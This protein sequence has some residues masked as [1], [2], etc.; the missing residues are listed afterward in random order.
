MCERWRELPSGIDCIDLEARYIWQSSLDSSQLSYLAIEV[1]GKPDPKL[2]GAGYQRGG[3]PVYESVS[4]RGRRARLFGDQTLMTMRWQARRDL[5]V[6]LE[7]RD[8]SGVRTPDTLRRMVLEFAR[9]LR[10]VETNPAATSYVLR[11]GSTK[12]EYAQ[13][14]DRQGARWTLT[15]R[16]QDRLVCATLLD[17]TNCVT[18]AEPEESARI[19]EEGDLRGAALG[20]L[21]QCPEPWVATQGIV[22]GSTPERTRRVVISYARRSKGTSSSYFVS[23]DALSVPGAHALRVFVVALDEPLSAGVSARDAADNAIAAVDLPRFTYTCA[24]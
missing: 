17:L 15:W 23:T 10:P 3:Y 8:A 5:H 11:S 19:H 12:F 2:A 1:V 6:F 7:V 14:G 22:F 13:T 20:V 16:P 9:G 4:V 21:R 24:P 18:P